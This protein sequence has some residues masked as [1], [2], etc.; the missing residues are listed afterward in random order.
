M[1]GREEEKKRM[2]G[3]RGKR[4]KVRGATYKSGFVQMPRLIFT[5]VQFDRIWRRMVS[6]IGYSVWCSRHQCFW[7]EWMN[8]WMD[9]WMDE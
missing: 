5:S 8:E 2:R 9:G 3:E 1:A 6:P 4:G 7:K